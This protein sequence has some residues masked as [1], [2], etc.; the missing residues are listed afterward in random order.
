MRILTLLLFLLACTD[1]FPETIQK[2]T[3]ESGQVHYGD[4]PP[5]VPPQNLQELLIEN[6]FDPVAYE[7]AI[8][9]NKA[10]DAEISKIESRE[11]EDQ[12]KAEKA[13]DDYF[14]GL[15]RKNKELER[16]KLSRRKS[17]NSDRNKASIKLKRSKRLIKD[18]KPE[19]T[20]R[21]S[22]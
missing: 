19:S 18:S 7:Q 8:L 4:K 3:D 13:L 20:Y 17:R 16:E 2:W 9:R 6:D 14:E 10:L 11:K 1:S 5:A 12:R 22:F 15:D 21:R